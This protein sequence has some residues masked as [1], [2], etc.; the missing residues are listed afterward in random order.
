MLISIKSGIY[1]CPLLKALAAKL[2]SPFPQLDE[3]LRSM[4]NTIS[5]GSPPITNPREGGIE[6]LEQLSPRAQKIYF[7]LKAAVEQRQKEQR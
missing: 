5:T 6:S 7:D 2:L 4:G 3:R 1:D